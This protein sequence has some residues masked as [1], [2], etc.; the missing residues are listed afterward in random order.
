MYHTNVYV[1]EKYTE[2]SASF[3]ASLSGEVFSTLR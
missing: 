3:S 1:T 2:V